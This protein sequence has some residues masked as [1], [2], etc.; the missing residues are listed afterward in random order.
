M[1]KI[2][3]FLLTLCI[4]L[5]VLLVPVSATDVSSTV[6]YGCHLDKTTVV[7]DLTGAKIGDGVFSA[8]DYPFDATA[9]DSDGEPSMQ[10]LSF[11]E[12]GYGDLKPANAGY[13]DYSLYLYVYNPTNAE[14]ENSLHNTVTLAVGS[15][16]YKK[17]GLNLISAGGDTEHKNLFLK[18]KVGASATQ[19]RQLLEEGGERSY[20]VAEFELHDIG[21]WQTAKKRAESNC[22]TFTGTMAGYGSESDTLQCSVSG[23]EVLQL[24]LHST[25]YRKDTPKVGGTSYYDQ[26][27]SAYF[28]IPKSY[29]ENY[30]T[31]FDVHFD[32]YVYG[33]KPIYVLSESNK[34]AYE[35]LITLL[36]Q[37][38]GEEVNEDFGYKIYGY[39]TGHPNY[40]EEFVDGKLESSLLHGGINSYYHVFN[41]DF[42]LSDF[43]RSREQAIYWLFYNESDDVD[44]VISGGELEAYAKNFIKNYGEVA[45]GILYAGKYPSFLFDSPTGGFESGYN[46]FH[47]T[48]G[49]DLTL[50]FSELT[51]SGWLY[52]S[53]T[54]GDFDTI[55]KTIEAIL[56]IFSSDFE[57]ISAEVF[58]DRYY[59]AAQDYDTLKA[60][61]SAAEANGEQTYLIR[62]SVTEYQA[63]SAFVDAVDESTWC[64]QDDGSV[65]AKQTVFLDLDVID[66]TFEND[67]VLTVIP[68]VSTSIDV[69]NDITRP[70]A[71]EDTWTWWETV[72]LVALLLVV[73]VVLV[74]FVK[75]LWSFCVSIVKGVYFII[76]WSVIIITWPVRAII[77]LFRK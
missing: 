22:Y 54:G 46:D 4:V 5:P 56:P 17:Y 33:T 24:D 16:S 20:S 55:N 72:I 58:C 53:F 73:F 71:T 42:S 61:V 44:S 76:K 15:G 3:L 40:Y 75:P 37:E 36:G 48:V 34:V 32:A 38:T 30:G 25:Y 57:G 59:V 10:V 29:I 1:K 27:N 12:Y 69:F 64:D 62:H 60:Y 41:D 8:A 18:F 19:L 67:D 63:Y 31:L 2:L 13:G 23:F 21:A 7:E 14:V 43:I 39:I 70:P 51:S 77:N 66:V 35:K 68:V 65:I 9:K 6:T 49:Q 45:T 47:A 28:S 50:T 26:L 74:F 52:N 11:F